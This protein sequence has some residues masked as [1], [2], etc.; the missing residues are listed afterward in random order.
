[1]RSARNSASP[2]STTTR[3]DLAAGSPRPMRPIVCDQRAAVGQSLRVNHESCV[4]PRSGTAAA[5]RASVVGDVVGDDGNEKPPFVDVP[6]AQQERRDSRKQVS[7]GWSQQILRVR[8]DRHP[9]HAEPLG[10][11]RHA[12]A[13]CPRG[14]NS[15][16]FAVRQGCSSSSPRVGYPRPPKQQVTGGARVLTRGDRHGHWPFIGHSS[17]LS[18]PG[19]G[20]A[21]TG[22]I[23]LGHSCAL[24]RHGHRTSSRD[25]S[26]LFS[27]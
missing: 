17:V 10:D 19:T 20:G 12:L 26:S 5:E 8:P 15:V 14:S 16:H 1:M 18:H 22:S 23:H 3:T 27:P 21:A 25:P 9:M 7:L 11:G 24:R 2:R 4:S 13:V 6:H